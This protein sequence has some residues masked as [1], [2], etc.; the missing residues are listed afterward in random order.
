MPYSK[1]TIDKM[2]DINNQVE[3]SKITSLYF[4][5]SSNC[6]LFTGFEQY[7]NNALNGNWDY[8]KS[9]ISYCLK[10][11]CDVIYLL[12]NP[13]RLQIENP[14]FE[15]KI[16]KLNNLLV[17]LQKLGVKK[18]R[19]AEHKLISYIEKYYPYFDI[20]ASTSFEFKS[21][22]EYRNFIFM[23]P[24]VK[25][26]VPSHDSI[27]NFTLLKNLKKLL[28][29]IEIE[30]M[31]NEGCI[32]GCPNRD[33]HASEIMNQK[34]INNNI[35]LSN[36]YYTNMFC[37]KINPIISMVFANNIFPWEIKEYSKI[38]I[39]N[40]KL[41]GRDA[42]INNIKVYLENYLSYLKGIENQKIIQNES[43]V[44]FIHHLSE[45]NFLKQFIVK[46]YK[47]YMPN[48][49]YF[50]KHGKFCAVNCGINCVYCYKCVEKIQKTFDNIRKK[51]EIIDFCKI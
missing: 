13:S 20:Y 11:E 21:I 36:I 39:N 31:V 33:G 29:N 48:I 46:D 35:T 41:V 16:N 30:L 34:T 47:N 32:K 40:F 18:L 44:S 7:R 42:F 43:I 27:K 10:K 26:I 12:N 45:N 4:S 19:I 49:S 28:P 1:E 8:W 3:K 2:L 50:K 9:L 38:G 15:Q 6:E 17:E 14:N 23:H 22:A 24:N 37:N 25:Q 51:I 5:L